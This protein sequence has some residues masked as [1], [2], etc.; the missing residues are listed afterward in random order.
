MS[1]IFKVLKTVGNA[2]AAV[3]IWLA[4]ILEGGKK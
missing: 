2:S 1:T 3:I 4:K